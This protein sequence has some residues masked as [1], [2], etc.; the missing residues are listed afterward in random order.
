VET[1]K[2][3]K[4]IRVYTF[5]F[6]LMLILLL[7]SMIGT[8]VWADKPADK[9]GK[10]GKS[11]KTWD[12][13]IRIGE[14]G[15]DIVLQTPDHEDG[16]Y[17]FAEDVPCSGGL[18][19]LPKEKGNWRTRYAFGHVDLF[20]WEGDDCGTYF[21]AP[22][23]DNSNPEINLDQFYDQL[24]DLTTRVSIQHDINPLTEENYWKYYLSWLDDSTANLD[25][26]YEFRASTNPDYAAEGTLTDDVWTVPFNEA[27]ATLYYYSDGE[28][29]VPPTLRWEGPV[30]FTVE[31]TRSPHVPA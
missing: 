28:P 3:S 9:P 21:M 22:V 8:T 4:S 1:I 30:S 23:P 2:N 26:W 13:K 17:L 6:V 29:P 15:E 31:I 7:S 10:S 12:L 16:V 24:N 20:G 27:S 14:T 25:D 18:W 5:V 19:N 11:V